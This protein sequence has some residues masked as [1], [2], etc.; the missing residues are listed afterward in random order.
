MSVQKQG[1]L[2]KVQI[3][4]KV[5]RVVL[6]RP[7]SLN[8]LDL[9]LMSGLLSALKEI[10]RDP[11][12]AIVVLTG[13]GKGFS[14]GGDIKSMLSLGN[15]GDF[16]EVMDVINELAM[17]LY[18]LPKIVVAGIHG[19]AA[20]LGFSL[21]L[22]AD[23][24]LCEEDSKLAMNFI[25]IGL[26][27][28]GGS[29]FLL[30]ERLGTHKAKRMIWNGKVMLGQ[31]ALMKGLVDEAL[32]SGKLAEGLERYIEQC[33]QSPVKALLK[34][35]EIYTELN[36]ERLQ[37]ALLKEKDGQWLMRQTSDHQEGIKA[38]IEKRRPSFKGE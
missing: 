12:L 17:T 5:A 21:A 16:S 27:P 9:D 25:G 19:A 35:K 29:H 36:K 23:Y 26:I 8:A 7:E 30:Q 32:P 24:I 3:E 13:E 22:T 37:E 11:D 1:E 31:E 6:N 10:R 15:E 4:G 14:S 20:G 28:D 18:T 38:F 34:T 33:V 2:V